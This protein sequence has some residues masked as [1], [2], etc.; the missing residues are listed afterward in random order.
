MSDTAVLLTRHFDLSLVLPKA[1]REHLEVIR[2]RQNRAASQISLASNVSEFVE[3]KIEEI[4][5]GQEFA[6]SLKADF[7]QAFESGTLNKE[8]RDEAVKSVDEESNLRQQEVVILKRQRKT[9]GDDLQ[10]AA[11]KPSRFARAYT[12]LMEGKVMAKQRRTRKFDQSRFKRDVVKRYDSMRIDFIG[13]REIFCHFTGVWHR[14]YDT[15]AVH[16]VSICLE[17]EALAYLFGAGEEVVSQTTNGMSNPRRSVLV[18]TNSIRSI[19]HNV[20]Q[21]SRAGSGQRLDRFCSREAGGHQI[22]TALF[23]I[24]NTYELYNSHRLYNSMIIRIPN[25]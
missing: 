11:A 3:A 4:K 23:V 14:A 24:S 7:R 20:M 8:Q 17:S 10:D 25:H 21:R 12:S 22:T 16:F 1:A 19:R 5:L 2:E 6:D 18:S 15:R 9:F 13:R